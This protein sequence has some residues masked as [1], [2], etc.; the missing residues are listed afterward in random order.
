MIAAAIY[1]FGLYPSKAANPPQCVVQGAF[2]EVLETGRRPKLFTLAGG[3]VSE[4]RR[5][6]LTFVH[7]R[8]GGE[9]DPQQTILL[10]PPRCMTSN[11]RSRLGKFGTLALPAR[12][13]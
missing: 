6:N 10:P 5:R 8:L 3:L 2:R 9:L 13:R 1:V 7:Q 12:T 4:S 11:D